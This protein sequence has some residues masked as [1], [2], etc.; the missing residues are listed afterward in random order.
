MRFNN[1]I[2]IGIMTF[3]VFASLLILTLR[4]GNFNFSKTG[5]IVRVEFENVDGVST[6]SPV[7][8]NGL[9]VGIVR[10]VI[11]KDKED[12]TK[13]E[14]V[15]FLKG[16]AK[17]RKGSKA[18]IKNLGFMGE[19]YVGLVSAGARGDYL[20]SGTLIV[21]EEP[22]DF[23]Q[24][25][26]EGKEVAVQLKEISQNINERLKVNKDAIDEIVS[27]VNETMG[28]VS[29][30]TASVD[31]RLKTNEKSIDS[32][33][34]NLNQASKNLEELSNDLKLNPWK[35]LYREKAKRKPKK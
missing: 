4:T 26:L 30:I 1:E 17:L 23:G 29:S 3:A 16:K 11:V 12:V 9:E 5:T 28:N 20:P 22:S 14:L 35:L 33:V 27:S 25:L 15:L 31:E 19:K 10:D 24:L 34:V 21:G 2:K 7:M 8:F 32:I 6:N 13:I 18:Y